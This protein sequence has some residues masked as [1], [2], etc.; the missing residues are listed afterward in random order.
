MLVS[1]NHPVW[2]LQDYSD[3]I[4]LKGLWGVEWHNSGCVNSGYFD[5]IQPMDDLLR[6]GENVYPLATDDAHNFSHCFG[7]FVIVK[8]PELKHEAV[9]DALERG[10]FYSSTKPLINEL[11]IEDKIIHISTSKVKKIIVTADKRYTYPVIAKD[12]EYL[13]EEAIDISWFLARCD[14]SL[15]K[16]EYIRI[17]VIDEEGNH[18]YTRAYHINEL[19]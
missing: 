1:L 4:G 6:V 17:T 13:T 16:Y 3:Y 10:D 19:I 12:G 7:G 11:Y 18:A 15:S 5:T 2:S 9:Y 8:A 14:S